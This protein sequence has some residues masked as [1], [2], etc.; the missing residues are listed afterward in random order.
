MVE[1]VCWLFVSVNDALDIRCL[2][3]HSAAGFVGAAD[4]KNR[5]EWRFCVRD[6]HV[7]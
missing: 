3:A 4:K 6:H 1:S 5:L 7:F 2:K